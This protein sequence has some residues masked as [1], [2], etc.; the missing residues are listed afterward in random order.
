MATFT[1]GLASGIDSGLIIEQLVS[2]RG[3][4]INQVKQRAATMT[5]RV[6]AFGQLAEKLAQLGKATAALAEDGVGRAQVV[7]STQSFTAT[8]TGG[9]TG[10]HSISVEQIATPARLRSSGILPDAPVT[11]GTLEIAV[12]GTSHT[13]EITEGMKLADVARAI[14]SS[15][16]PVNAVVIDDGTRSWLS[17]TNRDTGHPIGGDPNE[18]L[19]I[20]QTLTGST[21]TALFATDPSVPGAPTIIRA[22]ATNARIVVDGLAIER[23]SN[24]IA[25]VIPGTTLNL[26]RPS[27]TPED[28]VLVG[29]RDATRT[30]LDTFIEAW[31]ELVRTARG[32]GATTDGTVGAL[33][34][35]STLRSLGSE[36]EMVLGQ[37]GG[38]GAFA[39]LADIGIELQ[40]DGT[41]QVNESLFDRA[42]A[43]DPGAIDR[44]FSAPDTGVAASLAALVDR[45]NAPETGILVTRREGLEETV[46]RMNDDIARKT[47]SLEIYRQTLIRQFTALEETVS[48]FDSIARFLDQQDAAREQKK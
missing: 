33:A 48:R 40:R 21:G 38:A 20:A 5:S 42:L 4:A 17:L 46:Q 32:L 22:A 34:G 13:V 9:A 12:G 36:L 23:T 14:A 10:T 25:D 8:T 19:V 16:A 37:V 3:Q 1:G 7:G 41:L 35:D 44:L 2:L 11:A 15:G 45:Y 47:E 31:N 43:S 24:V 26:F 18:A 29:D 6:S 28:L 27:A 39:T 30:N